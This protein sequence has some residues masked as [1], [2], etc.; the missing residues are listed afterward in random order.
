MCSREGGLPEAAALTREVSVGLAD[1]QSGLVPRLPAWRRS[2][3]LERGF[4]PVVWGGR[5]AAADEGNETGPRRACAVQ[6]NA[7]WRREQS[8]DIRRVC[9][10]HGFGGRGKVWL[11][12][13]TVARGRR[14]QRHYSEYLSAFAHPAGRG[15]QKRGRRPESLD[16]AAAAGR[17]ARGTPGSRSSF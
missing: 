6:A 14:R 15:R 8:E 7:S 5:P 4:P 1:A 10:C 13:F 2:H 16:T 9:E 3:F 12:V 17:A 11:T